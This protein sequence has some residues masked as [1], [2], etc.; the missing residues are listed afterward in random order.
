MGL[1]RKGPVALG[2]PICSSHG[3]P[4]HTGWMAYRASE[5]K[6][7]T[8]VSQYNFQ[9]NSTYLINTSL[10][11]DNTMYKRF[12]KTSPYKPTN[13]LDLFVVACDVD[14]LMPWTTWIRSRES[15]ICICTD[16]HPGG[17]RCQH[18]DICT[19]PAPTCT[20][21]KLLLLGSVGP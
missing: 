19:E 2:I 12:R 4:L 8:Y 17:S 9:D 18:L 16:R 20:I 10:K 5:S 14:G 6:K 3:I 11:F 15:H 1:P 21:V 13:V 7:F